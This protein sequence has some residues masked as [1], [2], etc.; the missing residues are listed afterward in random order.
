LKGFP[1]SE[2]QYRKQSPVLEI[3]DRCPLHIRRALLL[4]VIV[5]G[6]AA[7]VASV[8]RTDRVGKG[9]GSGPHIA[10]RPARTPPGPASE[11]VQARFRVGRGMAIRRL[12]VGR[13]AV[14]TIAVPTAGLVSIRGLGLSDAAEPGT[15]A[16]FDVFETR[17]GRFAVVF[18]PAGDDRQ[19]R[20]GTLVL[21]R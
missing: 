11:P 21:R 13:S 18:S 8:A 9:S 6:L 3:Y 17:A 20:I 14:L 4:F 16:R 15:P 12:A 2:G 19:E 10:T 7:I 1:S 5:L